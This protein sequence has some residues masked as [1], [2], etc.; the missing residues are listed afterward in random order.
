M[1]LQPL[2]SYFVAI[3]SF[4]FLA[5]LRCC[6]AVRHSVLDAFQGHR[7]HMQ[8]ELKGYGPIFEEQP[9]D[10]I[11]P[12]ESSD[13][14]VSMN[15][16]ARGIPA[17]IYKW[18]LNN[19]D[20]DITRGRHLMVGG[21]LEITNPEK[22][23]DEGIYVCIA[24]NI[25]GI[26]RSREA[27]LK[28]GYLNTF[29][30]EE[31]H[32]VKVR[33]GVGAVL[34][35]DPPRH[36]PDDLSYRW[37]LNDFPEF[38][39]LDKR[40]FVSQTN[41][42]LYI[43]KVEASDKGNYSCFVTSNSIAKSVFSSFIPL[44]P[45]PDRTKGYLPDIRVKFKDTYALLGQNVTLECFA[46]GNPVPEIRWSKYREPM[47]TTAEISVSGAVLKIFNIQFEDEGTYECEA[48]NH[49]GKDKHSA[50]VYV[51]AMPEWVE[52]IND[53]E[54]DLGSDLH[55]IC[56]A[57]GK[58]IPTIR[59]LKNGLPY[60]KG[61]LRLYDL[62]FDDA[63]MYQCVAENVHGI[64][65]SNAELKVIVLPP[66]FEFYPMKKKV[67]A[68]RGGHAIIECKPRAAPRPRITWSRGTEILVNSTRMRI[69]YDG[70]LEIIN[71]TRTDGGNYTCFVENNKGKANGS[72]TLVVTDSTRIILAPTN[73]D[74]TVGYNATMQCLADHDLTLDLTF[75]W[76][77]NGYPIDVDKESDH[78]ERS[79]MI[80]NN[81]E[82]IVKNAQLR[83][84]GRYT[85]VAQ[86]I[87][88]NATASAD[89]VVRGPPGPP[90]GLRIE[91]IRNTS[92]VI[93]WSRG[94]DNHSPISNYTIQSRTPFHDDWKD[95]KT[96]PAIVEGN[97]E[98]A[99]LIDLI[100]WMEY[101]FRIMATNT[102]GTGDPSIPSKKI[103]TEGA[104]PNVAPSEVGGGGGR[105]RELTITW[106]P[107]PREYH[108]GHNFGYI[109]SFSPFNENSWKRVKVPQ[110]DASRY[111]HK[112]ESMLPTS[113]YQ[114]RV[115][116]FNNK[117]EGPDSITVSITSAEDAPT[118][119]PK[120]VDVKVRSATEVTVIW[121]QVI[122]QI[123]GYEIRYWPANE[124]DVT[125]NRVQ[126]SNQNFSVR[127]ENLK[128]DTRYAVRVFSF[129][130]AGFSPPSSQVYFTTQKA[131]PRQKPKITS[132]VKSGSKYII[133][134]DHVRS[135]SNESDVK[136]YKVLYRPDGQY[137][138]TL[139]TTGKHYI[140]V[141][142]PVK[143]QYVVEVRVHSDGGDGEVAQVKI[144]GAASGIS[145]NYLGF[146]LPIIGILAYLEF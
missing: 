129:N 89:L 80:K 134:W 116:A 98:S 6:S 4:F 29:T 84:A 24:S 1:K 50:N 23:R 65:Y 38:I 138:G 74:V 125:A 11:Y 106:V 13:G 20:I 5:G 96:D 57:A 66:T 41:G 90:G 110:S 68:A 42:N 39:T 71:V 10:T 115:R 124:K 61:E 16:R 46:L 95:T 117:G 108:F 40:R 88:D 64:I 78:Y 81:G 146:L 82:L 105:N 31:R 15:C 28:F 133:T 59:W 54:R 109:V 145:S 92:V 142:A 19:W 55:W 97:V 75:I 18:K 30:P 102:L 37:V 35:C 76:T 143:G 33:E 113:K 144:P 9:I 3:C 49:K 100:P 60:W 2:I 141:P 73:V 63:G 93:L 47:P 27:N 48:E 140:E 87:V 26:I 77:L 51:Q 85:C 21:N 94:T 86:T 126:V 53:T 43:A 69:W 45:Q 25:H 112:D 127:L 8:E 12:E 7:V 121:Q 67:L 101:E 123:D 91:N 58:P 137:N 128:P 56:T 103:R 118:E 139:V 17:P 131:P 62:K 104:P 99:K 44:I 83:H 114:A 34:L 136:G 22:S 70:S 111:V 14:R 132:Y 79:I 72:S 32:E 119:Q 122:Q 36:Y 135:D 120:R 52:H 107:L 130:S